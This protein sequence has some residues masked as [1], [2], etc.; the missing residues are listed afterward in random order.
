ML[1]GEQ[2]AWELIEARGPQE[3]CRESHA[4]HD[5]ATGC[6]LVRS[7]GHDFSLCPEERRVRGVSDGA[8]EFYVRHRVYFDHSVLCVLAAGRSVG[9]TGRLVKPANLPGGHHFFTRG[10]HVLPLDELASKYGSDREG[11]ISAGLAR[12]GIQVAYGDVA[13]ELSPVP[14]VP[15]VMILW[16]GDDEFPARADLLFDSSAE[17]TA[18]LDVLWA[19]AM[20]TWRSSRS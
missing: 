10:T 13:V 20:L 12:G 7:L 17:Y 9:R 16:L 2:K 15:V 1:S 5:T 6:Y 8:E 14:S 3:V 4:R 11:F 19:S 18:P